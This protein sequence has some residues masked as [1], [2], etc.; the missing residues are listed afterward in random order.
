MAEK[1]QPTKKSPMQVVK[2]TF[3]SKSG[4]V[5][6]ILTAINDS[7]PETRARLMRCSNA[8]LLKHHLHATRMAKKFG[9]KDGLVEAICKAKFPGQVAPAEYKS[10][11]ADYSPWRLMDLLRQVGG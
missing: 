3:G 6:Q 1:K 8:K 10:K 2:A 11:I 4:V 9:T 7:T 5:D